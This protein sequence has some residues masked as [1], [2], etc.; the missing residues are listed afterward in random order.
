MCWPDTILL[1]FATDIN[2]L[3]PTKSITLLHSRRRLLPKFDEEMHYEG[4]PSDLL[5]GNEDLTLIY[6][7]DESP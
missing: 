3:Y 1:E 6:N 4:E 2:A 5:N 7:S